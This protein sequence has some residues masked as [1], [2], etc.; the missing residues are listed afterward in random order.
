MWNNTGSVA[1]IY[2]YIEEG[3]VYVN[4]KN[5]DWDDDGTIL[6]ASRVRQGITV[7]ISN[8]DDWAESKISVEGPEIGGSLDFQFHKKQSS[9]VRNNNVVVSLENQRGDNLK[10]FAAP[11]GGVPVYTPK[12]KITPI[13]K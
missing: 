2:P 4:Q 5:F 9:L 10:F 7:P 11:I 6:V 13:G 3:V 8:E 1:H 12:P